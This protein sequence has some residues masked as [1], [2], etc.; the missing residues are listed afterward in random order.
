M[1]LS[2]GIRPPVPVP[3]S[4]GWVIADVGRETYDLIR[5]DL[6]AGGQL[7]RSSFDDGRMAFD[8]PASGE[9]LLEGITWE[10]Y[11][12]LVRALEE[13]RLRLTYDKG[14][15]SIVS[16]S[17]RHDKIK[18]LVGSFVGILA[19]ELRIPISSFG[20]TTWRHEGL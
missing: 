19:V 3:P 2:S 17:P 14:R 13:H 11:D 10:T 12:Q 18:H 20:S 4:R 9:L 6:D 15:L 16:P 8:R 5:R 1:S 7:L